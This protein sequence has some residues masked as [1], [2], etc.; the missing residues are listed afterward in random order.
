MTMRGPV[1]VSTVFT[2]NRDRLLTIKMAC[3]VMAA[4]SAHRK[5]ASLLSDDHFLIDGILVRA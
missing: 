3:K 1:R 2:K 5:G 4:I